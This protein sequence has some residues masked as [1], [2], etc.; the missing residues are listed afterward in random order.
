MPHTQG[1]FEVK[2]YT[3][4]VLSVWCDNMYMNVCTCVC[5]SMYMCIFEYVTK[6]S[7]NVCPLSY[8]VHVTFILFRVDNDLKRLKHRRV[9]LT[10]SDIATN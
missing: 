2:Y 6:V 8:C 3:K 1:G 9:H 4:I 10:G 5:V 7:T